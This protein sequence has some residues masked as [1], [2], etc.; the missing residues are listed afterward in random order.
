MPGLLFE[1]QCS[2]AR[3]MHAARKAADKEK[4]R[5]A[6]KIWSVAARTEQWGIQRK[7]QDYHG[8]SS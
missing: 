5:L 3:A 1:F 6:Q 7:M 8:G 4:A 2:W